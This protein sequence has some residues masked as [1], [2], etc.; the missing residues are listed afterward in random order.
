MRIQ[1]I[2]RFRPAPD[3]VTTVYVQLPL[4]LPVAVSRHR[5]PT[6]PKNVVIVGRIVDV[7]PQWS[8]IALHAIRTTIPATHHPREPPGRQSHDLLNLPSQSRP[9]AI[10]S[11]SSKPGSASSLSTS[12]PLA[13]DL[14]TSGTRSKSAT[15][16]IAPGPKQKHSSQRSAPVASTNGRFWE[17][18]IAPTGSISPTHAPAA[19]APQ[20][21][22]T[23]KPTP[24][25]GSKSRA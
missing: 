20:P 17:W 21:R 8:S 2:F 23:S 13:T 12:A 19:A 7:Q 1:R 3:F 4:P 14:M 10:P 6:N 9:G 24:R 18:R 5:P 11:T 16:V 25:T 22:S 15:R